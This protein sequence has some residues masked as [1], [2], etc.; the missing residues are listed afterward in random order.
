MPQSELDFLILAFPHFFITDIARIYARVKFDR[1]L[2]YEELL[3]DKY[4]FRLLKCPRKKYLGYP[5]GGQWKYECSICCLIFHKIFFSTCEKG[6]EFCK[7]CIQKTAQIALTQSGVAECMNETC[8]AEFDK[9]EEP[10]RSRLARRR[11]LV[12]LNK[13]KDV[14]TCQFC[15]YAAVVDPKVLNN[16]FLCENC[17][18]TH[19]RLCKVE[20]AGRHEGKT[21]EQARTEWEQ[22]QHA[23][24]EKQT[25]KITRKCPDC[26]TTFIKTDGCNFMKC[27]CGTGICYVCRKT[28]TQEGYHHFSMNGYDNKCKLF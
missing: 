9:I 27:S 23:N 24:E 3:S 26:K 22:K 11:L 21:C 6:H 17:W 8:D 14:E 16:V 18:R 19:C 10:L 20:Y 12:S 13:M 25:N 5:C 4:K 7:F 15:D 1:Q 2:A 28:I